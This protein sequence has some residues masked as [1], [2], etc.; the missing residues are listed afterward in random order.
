MSLLFAI[1]LGLY[2]GGHGTSLLTNGNPLGP[3]LMIVGGILVA[4][5]SVVG[6]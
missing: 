2:M 3:V 5:S 4:V 1:G 6:L